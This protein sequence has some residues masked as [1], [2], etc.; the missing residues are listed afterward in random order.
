[1]KKLV[2][3]GVAL[4]LI[5]MLSYGGWHLKRWFNYNWGYQSDVTET[6]CELVK[7][8]ALVDPTK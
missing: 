2:F 8:E 7:P 4:I 3:Y 5:A 6:I 1:M